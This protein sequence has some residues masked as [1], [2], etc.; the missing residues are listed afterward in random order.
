MNQLSLIPLILIPLILTSLW[1][2]FG[3]Q[4][5][6]FGKRRTK[7]KR[8]TPSDILESNA[9]ALGIRKSPQLGACVGHLDGRQRLW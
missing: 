4:R 5:F 2:F 7:L 1:G 3:V 9:S 6:R 8:C